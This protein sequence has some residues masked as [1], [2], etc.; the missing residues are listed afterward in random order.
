MVVVIFGVGLFGV[1][2]LLSSLL[3]LL[4]LFLLVTVDGADVVV[5]LVIFRLCAI[6]YFWSCSLFVVECSN[7]FRCRQISTVPASL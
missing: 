1:V 6:V 5:F 2:L 7:Y 4:L 3:L